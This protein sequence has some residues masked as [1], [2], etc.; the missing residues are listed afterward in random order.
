[1]GDDVE[2]AKEHVKATATP[3]ENM[4]TRTAALLAMWSFFILIEGTVRLLSWTNKAPEGWDG[5]GKYFPPVV[6]LIA[7]VV[8]VFFG[9]MGLFAGVGSFVFDMDHPMFTLLA[10]ASEL[11][12]GLYTYVVFNIAWPAMIQARAPYQINAGID[13]SRT[14]S[15][16]TQVFG[17]ILASC[18]YCGIVQGMQ[19]YFTIQLYH[20]QKEQADKYDRE[21]QKKRLFLYSFLTFFAGV[22][23]LICGC[24]LRSAYGSGPYKEDPQFNSVLYYFPNIIQYSSMTIVTGCLEIVYGLLG[25]ACAGGSKG[26][27]RMFLMFGAVTWLWLAGAHTLGQLGD[28]FPNGTDGGFSIWSGPGAQLMCL[29][30]SLVLAPAYFAYEVARD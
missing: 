20:I 14:N 22:S 6:L 2:N 15:N 5:S 3:S 18:M 8:E 30:T 4:K 7:A 23:I 24:I 19:V 28:G 17:W 9:L 29:H 10:A 12:F 11:I 13:L 27:F 26:L 21:Y 25:F 1:M 16:A